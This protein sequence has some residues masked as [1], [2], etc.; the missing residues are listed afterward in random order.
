MPLYV[1][2]NSGDPSN[3]TDVFAVATRSVPP[4]TAAAAGARAL[5]SAPAL[6]EPGDAFRQRVHDNLV[7]MLERRAD[8]K[9]GDDP[10]YQAYK[11][12]TPA[13]VL[14]FPRRSGA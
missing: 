1:R 5:R 3:R 14:W 11:R 7:R 13:L 4:L 9:W 8:A 10:D 12:S 2:T 6:A